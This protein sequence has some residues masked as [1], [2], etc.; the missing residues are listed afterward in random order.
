LN[1]YKYK[2]LIALITYSFADKKE[3]VFWL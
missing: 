1:K 2:L 3:L